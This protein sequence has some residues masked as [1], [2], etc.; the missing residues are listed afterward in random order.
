MGCF[1][2]KD[3]RKVSLHPTDTMTEHASFFDIGRK[4]NYARN[5]KFNQ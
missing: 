1:N 3:P 4:E 2:A 5:S